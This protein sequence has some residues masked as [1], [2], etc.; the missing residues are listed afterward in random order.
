MTRV[1][2]HPFVTV[3]D[4]L[5]A[6]CACDMNE[7]DDGE[8]IEEMIEEAS[9]FLCVA[10]GGRFTGVCEQTVRPITDGRC[11]DRYS[12]AG[13]TAPHEHYNWI[14]HYGTDSI[15]LNGPNTEVL[16]IVIDGQ[17][18]SPNEYGL[19]NGNKLFRRNNK[20]WPVYNDV[21][22]P[23]TEQG[24]FSITY[25][26]G[27]APT[28]IVRRACI[29]LVCQMIK[30]DEERMN[31]LRGVVSATVQGVNLSLDQ[32][33]DVAA[34]GLPE[35]TRFLDLYSPRGIGALG[36]YS[37]ELNHGWRLVVVEGPSGS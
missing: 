32:A 13:L 36:V 15:V 6:P 20:N 18:V 9:D 30:S 12:Y 10:S 17:V 1:A 27:V 28:A 11:Y 5:N 4:V 24:T 3:E 14:D 25:R 37:P 23:D 26:F 33:D 7:E 29:E 19:L 16:E 2:C 8:V 34:L 21:T 35:V 22:L 31:R